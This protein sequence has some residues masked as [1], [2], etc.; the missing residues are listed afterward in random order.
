MKKFLVFSV[1]TAMFVGF[2]G[3]GSSGGGGG[4]EAPT[5]TE[6]QD[7]KGVIEDGDTGVFPTSFKIT[8]DKAMDIDTITEAG[9]VLIECGDMGEPVATA[10]LDDTNEVLTVTVEDAYRYQLL[11][12][13]VTFTA[14]IKDLDGNAMEETKYT[15]TNA[16][17]VS[18][19][20]NAPSGFDGD[21][22]CWEIPADV[23]GMAQ[24]FKTWNALLNTTSG[25]ATFNTA[26]S[27]FDIDSKHKPEG[28]NITNVIVKPTGTVS[29]TSISIAF[30][31]TNISGY[32]NSDNTDDTLHAAIILDGKTYTFGLSGNN[33][34]K[35]C[36]LAEQKTGGMTAVLIECGEN[37][38]QFEF[39]FENDNIDVARF[40]SST[41]SDWTDFE[42]TIITAPSFEVGDQIEVALALFS[43][44]DDNKAKIQHWLVNGIE[45]EDQY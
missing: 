37:N 45:V 31:I 38:Y 11:E 6:I 7:A 30:E 43:T 19:D 3:C 4:G 24:T 29:S 41:D 34:V 2:L 26:G 27:S 9:N 14:E 25:Y 44:A 18:D 32:K 12:C 17:A 23:P 39:V 33:N 5:I 35:N 20:F 21:G 28:S 13:E 36:I 1:A 8:F 42:T 16:C 10:V 40:K 15:F 22:S